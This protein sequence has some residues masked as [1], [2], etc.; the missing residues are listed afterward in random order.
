MTQLSL[1]A[2]PIR[3]ERSEPMISGALLKHVVSTPRFILENCDCLLPNYPLW[4]LSCEGDGSAGIIGKRSAHRPT[5][6]QQMH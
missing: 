3:Y 4:I 1:H 6:L 2:C 5:L